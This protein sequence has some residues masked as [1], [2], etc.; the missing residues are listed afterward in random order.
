MLQHQ[1]QQQPG[2]KVEQ[3]HQERKDK[4]RVQSMSRRFSECDQSHDWGI[5]MRK[6]RF[7]APAFSRA[8]MLP[9]HQEQKEVGLSWRTGGGRRVRLALRARG[10]LQELPVCAMAK[11]VPARRRIELRQRMQDLN[12][13]AEIPMLLRRALFEQSRQWNSMRPV[14]FLRLEEHPSPALSCHRDTAAMTQSTRWNRGETLVMCEERCGQEEKSC[15]LLTDADAMYRTQCHL[16]RHPV[17]RDAWRWILVECR[18]ISADVLVDMAH[19]QK[20]AIHRTGR[21]V[22][23]VD[24]LVKSFDL[25]RSRRLLPCLSDRPGEHQNYIEQHPGLA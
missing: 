15:L 23:A 20:A 3:Q 22:A 9:I 11:S 19:W 18:S 8:Q 4:T 21:I 14:A 2:L 16:R 13:A 25:E 12:T 7:L 5:T 17:N 24:L 10:R 6:G 1:L